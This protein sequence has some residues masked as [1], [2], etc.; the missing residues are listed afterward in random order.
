MEESVALING[1]MTDVFNDILKIEEVTLRNGPFSDVSVTEVH[2]V[3]A[4]GMHMKRM[5]GEVAKKLNITA[6]TLS[7]AVNN[8]EKKGYVERFRDEDDRRAVK[9]GLTKKGR[10]LYR[11]HER[12]HVQMVRASITGL[13]ATEEEVLI[14]AFRGLHTFLSG[15]YRKGEAGEI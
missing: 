11:V 12:F 8:L 15:F 5:A 3:E 2:T 14:R 4:I 10:L 7:V 1:L 6:G 9:L 13:S